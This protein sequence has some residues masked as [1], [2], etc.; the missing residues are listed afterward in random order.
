MFEL[1]MLTTYCN[2]QCSPSMYV[3]VLLTILTIRPTIRKVVQHY[4]YVDRRY[5]P[6]VLWPSVRQG[7][8]SPCPINDVSVGMTSL[9]H[10]LATRVDTDTGNPGHISVPVRVPQDV[11]PADR[12]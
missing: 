4:S 10:P 9:L 3:Y 11:L 1:S 6:V 2:G 7:C 5:I 8:R 12:N